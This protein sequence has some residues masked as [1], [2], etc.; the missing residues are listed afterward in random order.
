ME[1]TTSAAMGSAPLWLGWC[2]ADPGSPAHTTSDAVSP[3]KSLQACQHVGRSSYMN[4]LRGNPHPA[5][6]ITPGRFWGRT[7]KDPPAKPNL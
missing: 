7:T 1:K 4:P 5:P 6:L 3:N 2:L